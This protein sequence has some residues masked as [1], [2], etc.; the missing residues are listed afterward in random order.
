[1][2]S[3]AVGDNATAG[4][5]A[6]EIGNSLGD[7]VGL[8]LAGGQELIEAV[9]SVG[10]A[11]SGVGDKSLELGALGTGKSSLDGLEIGLNLLKGLAVLGESSNICRGSVLAC[12][13]AKSRGWC[14]GKANQDVSGVC[15]AIEVRQQKRMGRTYR[16]GPRAG[17]EHGR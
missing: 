5:V 11:E 3:D 9:G 10:T 15:Y 7:G 13:R 12:E 2:Q 14:S 1:M 8:A 17:G 4:A 16:Q 6:A